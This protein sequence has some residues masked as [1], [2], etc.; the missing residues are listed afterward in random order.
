VEARANL[1][2][3]HEVERRGVPQGRGGQ[4]VLS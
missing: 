4:I 1:P 2:S 3:Y